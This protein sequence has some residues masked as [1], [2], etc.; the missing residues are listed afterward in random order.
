MDSF[1]NLSLH[2]CIYQASFAVV[3]MNDLNISMSYGDVMSPLLVQSFYTVNV[4]KNL[5]NNMFSINR[6]NSQC[7]ICP[8]INNMSFTTRFN[9]KLDTIVCQFSLP[10]LLTP[11]KFVFVLSTEKCYNIL[12]NT[13]LLATSLL[14]MQGFGCFPSQFNKICKFCLYVHKSLL[15]NL[16]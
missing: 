1:Q 16:K 9:C 5:H 10:C 15:L 13:I 2:L 7:C 8:V 4:F 14:L 6:K 12:D 11:P 3:S